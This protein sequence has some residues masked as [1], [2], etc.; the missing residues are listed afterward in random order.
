MI[1]IAKEQRADVKV[2]SGIIRYCNIA[3]KFHPC[4]LQSPRSSPSFFLLKKIMYKYR[5]ISCHVFRS[6]RLFPLKQS[7]TSF[8]KIAKSREKAVVVLYFTTGNT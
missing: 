3:Q 6:F 2:K 5:N 8:L 7:K 4:R 1:L